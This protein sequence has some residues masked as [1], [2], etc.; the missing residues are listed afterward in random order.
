MQPLT[1]QG[2]PPNQIATPKPAKRLTDAKGAATMYDVSWR[3]WLRW[4]DGGLVP[5]GYKIGGRRLWNIEELD[6]H[7]KTGCKP[8]RKGAAR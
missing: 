4:A 7:I 3:T 6:A 1:H 8:L 5:Q 2:S